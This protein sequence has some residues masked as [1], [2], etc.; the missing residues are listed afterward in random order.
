ME[1]LKIL[2]KNIFENK[3][4][5]FAFLFCTISLSLSKAGILWLIKNFLQKTISLD[6]PD[7]KGL[8]IAASIIFLVWILSAL[9]EYG[10]KVYQQNLMRSIEQNTLMKVVNHLLTLSVRFFDR[11]S[12]GDLLVTTRTDINAMRDMV[13]SYATILVSTF[14][15]ISLMVVAFKVNF[16][17][18]FWGLF[19]LP[20]ASG[21]LIYIGNKI[22]MAAE[23][24]RKI[25]YKIFDLLVQLFNGIRLIKV[26]KAEKEEEESIDILSKNYY[27]EFLRT[28]NLKALSGMVL[29]TISG[30]GMVFVVILGGIMVFKGKIDWPSLLAIIMVLLSLKEPAKNLV[31][32]QAILKELLPSLERLEKL[33]STK[34]D[35]EE[36]KNPI[37][38]IEPFKNLK[39]EKVYFAYDERLILR[40]ISLEVRAGET[41][42]I[43]GPSGVGKTTF[44]SLI[45]RFFD[46]T[47]G[48]IKINGIDLREIKIFDLMDKIA[49]V[50]Q[51][52]F[53]F[54][55]TIYENILYGK[56]DAK[57]EDVYEA[58]KLAYIHDEILELPQGYNTFVGIGGEKLSVGQKQ[59]INIARAILKKPEILLLDEATSSLDSIS[60][61]KVQKAIEN[62]MEGKTSFIIAHRISTLR[63]A[64]KI[65]VLN[66]GELEAIGTHE[67]L[68]EK[69]LT[70]KML[71][72][73]QTKFE[74]KGEENG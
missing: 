72:K 29:E 56:R 1:R 37:P 44:L 54:N 52:P 24:K 62:L 55:A 33:F 32:S 28:A 12:H 6:T 47:K 15:I 59:R 23:R 42:G 30:F 65:I 53:L 45:P 19:V 58:A 70:Y 34:T 20:L 38:F 22:R 71:W 26:N 3:F 39:F 49:I 13:S 43:V 67:E 17:L 73:T 4:L 27:K 46:P 64:N 21:P 40:N 31:H 61:A 25:G 11:S 57:E 50:T 68:L 10:S 41:V 66:N 16:S 69:N 18:T 2:L 5:F 60:E 14:T 36:A 74:L 48:C 7:F 9:F 63:N 8:Y 35:V 51:E